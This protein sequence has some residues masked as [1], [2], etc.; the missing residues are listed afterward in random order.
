[1]TEPSRVLIVGVTGYIG[2]HIAKASLALGHPTFLLVRPEI[3]SDIR[4]VE[5]II[6]LKISGARILE[7]SIHDHASLL[8]ALRQ[9]DVVISAVAENRL[10]EQ[11]KLIEAIK[12]VGTIKRFLP[13]EY[14]MDPDRMVHCLPPAGN[15]FSDKRQI[16]RAVEAAGIPFTY[17]SANCFAGYFLAGFAQYARFLPPKDSLLIYG[18]GNTKVIWVYEGDV[19]TYII[20]TIDD[21]RTVNKT[22]YLRPPANILSQIEVVSIWEKTSGKVLEKKFISEHEWLKQT[23]EEPDVEK[24]IVMGHLHEIFY[25]GVLY[26]FEADRD[27]EVAALYPEVEYMNVEA[28]LRRLA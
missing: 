3:A 9:V 16:R 27:A 10:L 11:L 18:D 6:S 22:L 24:K 7:G 12:E 1:M 4:K 8:V 20:K 21:P 15:I 17:F 2:R 26:N 14:G 13:S 23:E 5:I 28:Y 19:G 25:N